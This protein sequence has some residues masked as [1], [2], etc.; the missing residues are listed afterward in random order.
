VAYYKNKA[1]QFVLIYAHDRLTDTPKLNDQANITVSLY[2]GTAV[3]A[4]TNAV[5]QV[6]A[7]NHP[8][9][10]KLVLT[11]VETN[12]EALGVTA[13][14][15]T[16]GVQ[17]DPI[18]VTFQD[19]NSAL[20]TRILGLS[21]ENMVMDQ[22]VYS[23]SRMTGARIRLFGSDEFDAAVDTPVATYEL[24]IT[25][26]GTTSSVATWTMRKV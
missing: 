2:N 12:V 16:A 15:S 5:T 19:D 17:I 21:K 20:L 23:L 22:V 6:D 13:K 9:V 1:D 7:T 25:Y 18:L 26:V 3:A 24:T 11:Q 10:Y 4:A 8:G 14:S